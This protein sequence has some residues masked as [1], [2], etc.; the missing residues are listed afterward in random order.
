MCNYVMMDNASSGQICVTDTALQV[1]PCD[2][3]H[4]TPGTVIK[5]YGKL[6]LTSGDKPKMNGFVEQERFR[7]KE[8]TN[9]CRIMDAFSVDNIPVMNG[10][11]DEFVL[12]DKFYASVPGPTWPNRLFHLAGTSGGLTE[13]SVPWFRQEFGRL[14]P[15]R[16][17]LDQVQDAGMTWKMYVNDT[18]W[19][20]LLE[21]VA[22]NPDKVLLTEQL[23]HDARNGK[24]PNFAL[25]NPRAGVNFTTGQGS[26][27]Q[28][29]DHDMALGE[30]F[31]KDVYE[32]LRAG[33]QWNDTLLIITY[34]ENGGFYDHDPPPAWAPPPD[35]YTA[36]PDY[37]AYPSFFKFDRPGMRIPTVLVSPWVPKGMVVSHP[38][39]A[40][41]PA[42]DSIFELT[43]IMATARKV[44]GISEGA[45]TKRDAWAATFD[46]VLDILQQP[47]TDCPMHLPDAKAPSQ[48]AYVEAELPINGLQ[49]HIAAVHGHLSGRGY[50]SH[51]ATQRDISKWLQESFDVHRQNVE[52]GKRR[53]KYKRGS[54][55]PTH[56][57]PLQTVVA[58]DVYVL[59]C[60]SYLAM[61]PQYVHNRWKIVLGGSSFKKRTVEAKL[62]RN[63]THEH[64]CW[65]ARANPTAGSHVRLAKCDG[66]AAQ[67]WFW[68]TDVTIRPAAA[69]NLC[70]TSHC[71]ADFPVVS[72]AV[73]LELCR[74]T[75]D[76]H[77]AYQG[78][79]RTDGKQDR[80]LI[81][82][83]AGT[84]ALVMTN[85]RR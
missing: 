54:Q 42:S 80:G 36:Y 73:I 14:F 68:E 84:M 58:D 82:S 63:E 33:P 17:I 40:A 61:N 70:V 64:W 41:K 20:L 35:D 31:Y 45:L 24:L 23:Y 13:S 60:E 85:R 75:V 72:T 51:I 1:A 69:A 16:T 8:R 74:G 50:P 57:L 25:V 39:A 65:T 34:D 28:H 67:N 48:P 9:Y 79:G 49:E 2:P 27:D 19:E 78:A 30:A 44:L 18:P 26:N 37:A 53:G 46:Y 15:F 11:A 71:R 43:S 3:D 29:P 22:Y 10:I 32:A 47:R 55:M 77:F 59:R 83:G 4:G 21:T 5:M 6:N 38:P 7:G 66:S 12:F 56:S 52:D 81:T 76:Q 62:I